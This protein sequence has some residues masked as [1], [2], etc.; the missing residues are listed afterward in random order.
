MGGVV[1]GLVS[2]GHGAGEVSG[3]P[4]VESDDDIDSGGVTSTAGTHVYGET[5][6]QGSGC[7]PVSSRRTSWNPGGNT[8]E[9]S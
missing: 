8:P 7:L 4:D 9:D 1:D 6:N 3:F 2:Q 5:R